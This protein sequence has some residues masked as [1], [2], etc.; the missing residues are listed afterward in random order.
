MHS[1]P[2]WR[3]L[4]GAICL[5]AIADGLAAQIEA[6]VTAENEWFYDS[7]NGKRLARLLPG[8]AVTAGQIDGGEITPAEHGLPKARPLQLGGAEARSL[9]D[10]ATKGGTG[11][12]HA[13]EILTG[14]GLSASYGRLE[15]FPGHAHSLIPPDLAT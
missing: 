13:G 2:A 10:G 12:V 3:T 9:D 1:Q 7:P 6:T 14:D 5:I 11:Q 15:L 4:L 8:A